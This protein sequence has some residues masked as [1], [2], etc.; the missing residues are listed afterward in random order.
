MKC[1]TLDGQGKLTPNDDVLALNPQS[2]LVHEFAHI[3]HGVANTFEEK[4]RVQDAVDLS[5]EDSLW[6]AASYALYLAGELPV[7]RTWLCVMKFG[8]EAVT[9]FRR[10]V[11]C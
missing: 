6:N 8:S 4:Y 10:S 9:A 3:Y 2:L 11:S 1:P 7:Q 5:E